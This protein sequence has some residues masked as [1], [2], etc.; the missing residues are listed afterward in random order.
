MYLIDLYKL[1]GYNITNILSDIIFAFILGVYM[2]KLKK[3]FLLLCLF[4]PLSFAGCNV[5]KGS[6]STPKIV[7]IKGGTIVFNT[8]KDADYYTI[9]INGNEIIVNPKQST[10]VDVEGKTVKYDASKIFTVGDDYSVKIK[11]N[12]SKKSSK[13]S[14]VYSYRHKGSVKKPTNVR[15]NSTTL[16]WDAVGNISYYSVKIITPKDTLI[17]DHDGNILQAIT[18]E[19]IATAD[20]TEYYFNTNSFDFSSIITQAGVY[21]FYV[22]S[23]VADGMV[24]VESDYTS[25]VSYTNIVELSTPINGKIYKNAGNLYLMTILDPNSNAISITCENLEKTLEING[26]N[27]SITRLSGNVVNVNLTKFFET[28]VEDGSLNFDNYTTYTFKV[29]SRYISPNPEV[30]FYT[31]SQESSNITFENTTRLKAPTVTLEKNEDGTHLISWESEETEFLTAHKLIVCTPTEVKEYPLSLSINNMILGDD[32]V[33]ASVQAIGKGN[34][35]SSTFSDFV[36]PIDESYEEDVSLSASGLYLS[37]TTPASYAVIIVNDEYHVANSTSY[38]FSEE[39]FETK[40]LPFKHYL[41]QEGKRFKTTSGT[42]EFKVPLTTPVFGENQ[43]FVSSNIYELTFT[44]SENA[45]GY[46][47]WVKGQNSATA[48]KIETL[49]TSTTIDLSEYIISTEAFSDY[50]VYV[51]A[52]ADANGLYAD[53]SLSSYAKVSH[54]KVLDTPKFYEINGVE[55]PVIKDMS[56]GSPKYILKFYHVEDAASYELLVNFNKLVVPAESEQDVYSVDITN[57]LT[58]ANKYEIRIQAIPHSS[59]KKIVASEYGVTYYSILKQL[60]MVNNV[61]IME[62]EGIYTLSFDPVDNAEKYLVRI[63]KENDS[64]YIDY[65]TGLGLHNQIEVKNAIDVTSYVKQGGV[66]NFYVTALAPDTNTYYADSNESINYAT[67]NKLTTLQKPTNIGYDNVSSSTYL[68]YWTGDEHAD[69]YKIKLTDPNGVVYDINSY[70]SESININDYMTIQGNYSFAIYSM[71]NSTGEN[72]K[73]Y[74][75]SSST[76]Y[77]MKYSYIYEK[78]FLRYSVRMNGF[79]T[80]FVVTSIDNLKNLLWHHYLFGTGYEGLSV[81]IKHGETAKEEIVRLSIEATKQNL[82]NFTGSNT[83]ETLIEYPNHIDKTSGDSK[84]YSM[85]TEENASNLELFKYLCVQLLN[86]YPELNVLS[87]FTIDID[88][89]NSTTT[90]TIFNMSYANSLDGEKISLTTDQTINTIINY[91]TPYKYIDPNARKSAL[92]AFPIDTR[93]EAFVET[94]EQLL[95]IVQHNMKPRFIGDSQTAETVY[96][97]AKLVLSAIVTNNMSDLDKVTAIFDWLEANFELTFYNIKNSPYISGA[98][99]QDDMAQFGKYKNYYLEGIFEDIELNS[100][101][102]NIIVGSKLATSWSYSKAFALLC[103]IEGID[104]RVIYGTYDFEDTHIVGSNKTKTA[105]HVWN[106]VRLNTTESS[107]ARSTGEKSWYAVDL[108]FSDNRVIYNNLATSYGISSHSHFLVRDAFIKGEANAS[109]IPTD[110]KVE[111]VEKTYLMGSSYEAEMACLTSYDYYSNSSFGLTY[112]EIDKT[113]MDFETPSVKGY[114]YL[115]T[116]I[117]N[118][119]DP[120]ASYQT[121]SGT[122]GFGPF[123]AYLLN[124]LIYTAHEAG[125]NPTGR[126]IFEFTFSI[127][128]NSNQYNFDVANLTKA[129]GAIK[130]QYQSNITLKNDEGQTT[131]FY[132]IANPLDKT[133]T[134]IFAVQKPV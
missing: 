88:T 36:Y 64:G 85:I 2:K 55:T 31:D 78:D 92:G 39:D 49:Y 76:T 84:W 29:K 93:R 116:Y 46:Y 79:S 98:V 45:I 20:I 97:N 132:T 87:D 90:E 99:E 82:H 101:N 14:T 67:L 48:K 24:Y 37:W 28:Y 43:G 113:I 106:K 1:F 134:V 81:M 66:Y 3:L 56:S 89:D 111:L 105:N 73:E 44:G 125:L 77:N 69:Y 75:S 109:N 102:G 62:N 30:S 112:A 127:A 5:G 61:R 32:F 11:A 121:Y 108:T 74:A 71:V 59:N 83:L 50:Y 58:A 10:Y 25:A 65:L 107:V 54:I 133:V 70:M 104:A 51:Q 60:P 38:M 95:Q 118:T 80:N 124:A 34:Y 17:L 115:R 86:I 33:A 130:S 53:S 9:S 15:I 22:S 7:E 52:V 91:G 117:S 110:F 94:T 128:G 129:Y 16:T 119:E 19:T 26:S 21:K 122:A 120:S 6:L 27:S 18:P 100:T 72:A 13:Y 126:S 40:R 12:A 41:I 114:S 23:V 47:V 42:A 68:L 96:N 103:A 131:D 123:E 8:I 57:Y 63:L 35:L 4:I